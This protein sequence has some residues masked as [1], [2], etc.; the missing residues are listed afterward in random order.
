MT[1]DR[2]DQISRLY[3]AALARDS[4]EPSSSTPARATTRCVSRLNRYPHGA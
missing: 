2:L 4:G 1:S 3:H